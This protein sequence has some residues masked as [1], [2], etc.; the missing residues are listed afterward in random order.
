M[1]RTAVLRG[2][3][4]ML[5][6]AIGVAA[7]LLTGTI[8]A[9]VQGPAGDLERS[10]VFGAAPA[11]PGGVIG[12]LVVAALVGLLPGVREIQVTAARTLLRTRATLVVP[13]PMLARHRMRTAAWTVF[14]TVAGLVAGFSVFGLLPGAVLTLLWTVGGQRD[15][16]EGLG[17]DYPTGSLLLIGFVL[18][19]GAVV[20]VLGCGWSA[21]RLAPVLLGPSPADRLALAEARLAQE[22]RHTALA[23]ELHDGIGHALSIISIQAAAAQ[24]VAGTRPDRAAAALTV[25]EQTSRGAQNELDH[26]LGL[27]RD[28]HALPA[29]ATTDHGLSELLAR[30]R[31]TGLTID[32]HDTH[33]EVPHVVWSTMLDILAEALTNARRH[34]GADTVTVTVAQTADTLE[35]HVTN[36]LPPHQRTRRT[37]PA[38]RG[39]TG[40]QERAA[41]LEGTVTA[42]PADPNTTRTKR[43]WQIVASIPVPRARPP[44]TGQS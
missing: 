38:G 14:Q 8:I 19:L 2:A 31:E 3:W 24:R 37:T 21:V 22:Q 17:W 40:M 9:I 25:I 39:I 18:L 41:L 32:V 43:E 16:L 29:R 27:L 6:A 33:R 20:G 13:D 35:L 28:P 44:R 1:I 26:L 7:V 34:G 10:T 42:G 23:R 15:R 4:L 30:Y 11:L 36:P 5:G 12:A